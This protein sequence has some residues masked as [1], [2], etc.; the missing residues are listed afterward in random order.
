MW[1]IRGLQIEWLVSIMGDTWENDIGI[2]TG[3]TQIRKVCVY[4]E[5]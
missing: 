5:A 1:P 2:K 4:N 3:G